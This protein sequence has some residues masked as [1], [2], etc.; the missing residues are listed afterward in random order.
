M[1]L[2]HSL[3]TTLRL[4]PM[5]ALLLGGSL[6]LPA[7]DG[8][9]KDKKPAATKKAG[10]KKGKKK[11]KKA[12]KTEAATVAASTAAPAAAQTPAKTLLPEEAARELEWFNTEVRCIG[13]CS[14]S[15][16]E[17][18]AAVRSLYPKAAPIAAA[19]REAGGV[20]VLLKLQEEQQKKRSELIKQ[21]REQHQLTHD[22]L[23]AKPELLTAEL[24][25]F[26]QEWE[27]VMTKYKLDPRQ[28]LYN[29]G[30]EPLK[31][32]VRAFILACYGI[33]I[34]AQTA[35]ADATPQ[36]A[37]AATLEWVQTLSDIVNSKQPPTEQAEAICR[38]NL[39]FTPYALALLS[40][41]EL[42]KGTV[43]L[44]QSNDALKQKAMELFHIWRAHEEDNYGGCMPLKSAFET[45]QYLWNVSIERLGH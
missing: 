14:L 12:Q 28:G 11:K 32:D 1:H 31:E 19:A 24:R 8:G 15:P 9:Q 35:A 39:N 26:M 40:Q 4:L 6:L 43:E 10:K 37:S 20:K 33:P 29:D 16:E 34:E 41:D 21:L 2:P 30:M 45:Y 42:H 17:K 5:A 44:L 7:C 13:N 25:T 27:R 18:L 36:Q 22:E 38:N 3:H 23:I